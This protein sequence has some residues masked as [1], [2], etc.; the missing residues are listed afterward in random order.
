MG[1]IS[2]YPVGAKIV[3]N[4][5][6]NNLCTK[7]EAERLI[8]F[9][10]NSG[11]LFIVGTVGVGMFYS[12]S[13]GLILLFTHVLSCL[14]VGFLFRWWGKSHENADRS[15][16]YFSNN[17]TLSFYNLGEIY[18]C[19]DICLKNAKK[20]GNSFDREFCFLFIHGLL[21]LLG[22]DHQT[23]EQEEVM[24]KLQDEIL[25]PKEN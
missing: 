3:A 25:P 6:E 4:L 11:P 17:N 10:N 5:K 16:E 8:A 12:P 7:L 22:Y 24:F 23:K 1:I 14:T 19:Y 13:L 21:H 20:Y 9:T 15:S 2:G 18:I